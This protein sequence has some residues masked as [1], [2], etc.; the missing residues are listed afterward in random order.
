MD[1][2]LTE[3]FRAFEPTN[4]AVTRVEAGVMAALDARSALEAPLPS[5][6]REW[7]DL[8]A[9]RPVANTALLV[10]AAAMLLITTP[11]A[12]LPFMLLG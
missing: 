6:A 1:E 3:A 7:L 4:E 11:L 10:A 9:S 5:L 12:A 8:V 2:R